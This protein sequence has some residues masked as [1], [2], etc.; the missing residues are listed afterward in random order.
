M[1]I[2]DELNWHVQSSYAKKTAPSSNIKVMDEDEPKEIIVHKN[3][4]YNQSKDVSESECNIVHGTL[5]QKNCADIPENVITELKNDE[6][7]EPSEIGK[8]KSY[9]NIFECSRNPLDQLDVTYQR[10][11]M[12]TPAQDEYYREMMKSL[13]RSNI[14][15]DGKICN[16][17]IHR[18][19]ID[20]RSKLDL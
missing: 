16:E 18:A 19:F 20:L 5:S 8:L 6:H 11:F 14:G 7:N 9:F 10:A 4:S 3:L 12:A 13:I 1:M 15:S 2:S 17:K